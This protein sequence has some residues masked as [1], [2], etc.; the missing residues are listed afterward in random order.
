MPKNVKIDVL[1]TT[2]WLNGIRDSV[3]IDESGE[4]GGGQKK[5]EEKEK[6][7]CCNLE[8]GADVNVTTKKLDSNLLCI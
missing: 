7:E 4:K 3:V 1:S 6:L 8:L 2:L 5:K